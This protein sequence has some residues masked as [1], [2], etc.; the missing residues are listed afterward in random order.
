MRKFFVIVN[1]HANNGI[2]AQNWSMTEEVLQ[3]KNIQYYKNF[4]TQP[5]DAYQ[6]AHDL[7]LLLRP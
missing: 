2:A 1:K 7:S 4:T 3:H 5:G 6:L